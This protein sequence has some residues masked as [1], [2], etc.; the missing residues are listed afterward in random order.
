MLINN[1]IFNLFCQIKILYIFSKYY[2][3]V[4]LNK[5]Y[6]KLKNTIKEY[7]Y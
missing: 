3:I 1:I 6:T 5:M 4:L 7:A 2:I